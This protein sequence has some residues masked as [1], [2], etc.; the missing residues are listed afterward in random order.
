MTLKQKYPCLYV[1]ALKTLCKKRELEEYT[2]KCKK[3]KKKGPEKYHIY[4]HGYFFP[5]LQEQR[6]KGVLKMGK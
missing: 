6:A 1:F 4:L 5:W 2:D 3:F